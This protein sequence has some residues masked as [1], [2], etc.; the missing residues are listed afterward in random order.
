MSQFLMPSL[1]ADMADGILVEQLIARGDPVHRGDIIAAVETQKGAIEIEVFEDGFLDD[2]LVPLGTK[3][4]VGT[5]IANIRTSDTPDIPKP[6]DPPPPPRPSEAPQPTDPVVPP[7][8][9]EDPMPPPYQPPVQ[10]EELAGQDRQRVSPAARRRAAQIGVDLSALGTDRIIALG[11]LPDTPAA[12]P[13]SAMRQAISAAMSR[14][15]R[16]I[17]HYY[18]SDSID[19]TA[20]EDFITRHNA[21]LPP[22]ARLA[23]GAL[24]VRAVALAA[25]AFPEFNGHFENERFAPAP[26]VHLGMAINLRSGGLAAPA[27]YDASEGDLDALM[28]RLRDLV[29]R[30]KKGRFRARELT[31]PTI[32][33]TSLGDRGVRGITG[34]IFPPQ[35]AIVGIGTPSVQAAVIDD[36]IKPRRIADITLAADHRV[37][38]GHRGARFLRAIIDHLQHPETL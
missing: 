24:Y 32:T 3:V 21:N 15:K 23:I 34:V 26:A 2:W 27:L 10:P 12:E 13:M 28:A 38:D 11:D 16:E 35:V 37:S 8:L 17:P 30:V 5:P 31:D 22:D 1:G 25:Q 20:A 14:S 4:A 18:L 36:Q 19:L 29:A 6:V 9:P 7:D 33:L